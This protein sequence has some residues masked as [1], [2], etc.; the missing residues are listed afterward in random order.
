MKRIAYLGPQG[1]YAEEATFTL[2]PEDFVS[3]PH[4]SIQGTLRALAKGE[5]DFAVVPIENSI[6]GTVSATLDSLW[7]LPQ[8]QVFKALVL[9]IRHCLI[10][11]EP[12]IE[13]IRTVF[14]H[15]QAL[16]QCQGWLEEHLGAIPCVPTASTV[17]ALQKISSGVAVVASTRAAELY[18]LPIL[19]AGINDAPDNCTRFWLVGPPGQSL[20]QPTRTSIGFSLHNNRAGALHDAL[21]HFAIRN[22]N[23]A[24]LESRPTKKVIGEYLFF[25]DLEGDADQNPLKEALEELWASVEKLKILGTYPILALPQ[26]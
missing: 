4:P 20:A 21:T 15:P 10:T 5:A 14:S 7:V 9:P 6:E 17:E 16:A 24:K 12:S 26:A 11:Q 25:A 2:F 1:T 19:H 23:L 18:N 22:I 3:L 13:T 8:L